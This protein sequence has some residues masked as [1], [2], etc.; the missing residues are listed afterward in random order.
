MA[1]VKSRLRMK[2]S[3]KVLVVGTAL[4]SS[5]HASECANR[6]SLNGVCDTQ[7]SVCVCDEGWTGVDCGLLDLLAAPTDC[8]FHGESACGADGT[9]TSSWGGSVLR[10]PSGKGDGKTT[11]AMFAAEMTHHCTL[12]HWTTN[13]EVVLATSDTATGPFTEHFQII[14][15]WAHN[16]EAIHTA[17]GEVAVFTL[18]NGQ[19]G[20]GPEYDCDATPAPP[21]PKPYP[22]PPQTFT[23]NGV[24]NRTFL[25][26]HAPVSSYTKPEA[27]Q[28]YNATMMD[29]PDV[30]HFQ[31][32]WNPAPVALPDGRV[33]IMM[34]T[35]YSGFFKT[36]NNSVGG[37]AGET[38]VEGPTWRG[39]F[40][41]ISAKDITNCTHCEEDPF[42]WV[43]TRQNWHAL[44]HRMFDNGTD[45]NGFPD[46]R[47]DGTTPEKPCTSPEGMW[48]MGHS[49][50]DDGLTW[51]PI[52][53]A[54]NTTAFL[55]DGT[56][57]TFQSRERPKLIL[58]EDGRPG[59]LSNAVQPFQSGAGADGG[60]THTLVVPLNTGK[61]RARAA[62]LRA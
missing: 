13:S 60:V 57:V 18:G 27:W 3:L 6:C 50:S 62:A 1:A 19:A 33:R 7:N 56:S 29:L 24:S 2:S 61:N 31:G 15:P 51:S 59:W 34:H 35:G 21:K 12:A 48:S 32:N 43:D 25:I 46:W 30:F 53:R 28:A 45:C 10:L 42:M 16:P 26:H 39:P 55:V 22:K 17:D 36:S 40:K 4:A 37:W 23:G 54:A 47:P 44:Y 5:A 38:I 20:W 9:V 11:F 8:S 49:Y 52:T 14:K 58:D 41:V